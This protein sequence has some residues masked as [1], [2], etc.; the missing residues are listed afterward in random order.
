VST[1]KPTV[2]IVDDEARMGQ[3]LSMVLSRFGCEPRSFT[4]GQLALE[5]LKEQPPD[6]VITDLSMPTMDGLTLLKEIKRQDREL[7]VILI[8]AHATVTSA[9]TA[10]KEGAFDY[11]IKP[12]DNEDLTNLVSNAL[13]LARLSK[14]N[15]YLRTELKSRYLLDGMV[16]ESPEMQ[17]IFNL[18]G[19]VASSKATVLIT[20]ESGT[21]KELV[22]RAIHYSSPR[23]GR[24]F[25]AV[26]MSALS[27]TLL[28]SEMF[29]YDKGAFTGAMQAKKGRFELADSGTLFLDEIGEI[30]EAFQA[31]LLRVLQLGE[32][33]R[34]GGTS[35]LKV[36]L[37][38]LAAT[39]RDL[40]A[41]VAAGRFREDLY[42]RL[43]VI[44]IRI[45]PLRER[46]KDIL[47]LAYHFLT[48]YR[49]E[50]EKPIKDFSDGVKEL[51]ISH[52]WPGNV[53]ELENTVER[54]VVLA[55]GEYLQEDDLLMTPH[56]SAPASPTGSPASSN[57]TLEAHL[58]DAAASYIRKVLAECK[59][60][61]LKA[62]DVLEINRATLYRLMK[63]Y[64]I[65][66]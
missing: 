1:R 63:K 23:L 4:D 30:S 37:R 35:T 34:V 32:F 10:M 50:M 44:P 28:E 54:G 58:D 66:E 52:D 2:F 59:G 27:E 42:F 19:Q 9:I 21:G 43:N 46:R 17:Q 62:A 29:G 40:P 3:V 8:T 56:R 48:K 16:G 25:V 20:G 31:K 53:R 7:P 5:A 14:E 60:A 57:Q 45:P 64:G 26:N 22:A 41:E 39:N 12:F 51:F 55:R 36:D 24:P 47:P 49:Q 33:E 61:R 18:V 6:L 11:I 65:T 15:K 13:A 38:V